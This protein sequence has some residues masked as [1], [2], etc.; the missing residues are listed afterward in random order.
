MA[1]DITN[2]FAGH[3]NGV[4]IEYGQSSFSGTGLTVQVPCSFGKITGC[5]ITPKQ[6]TNSA[7]RYVCDL[8]SDGGVTTV[9]RVC[10]LRQVSFP[11]DNAQS[12]SSN[13]PF[14]PLMIAQRGMVLSNVNWF[15]GTSWGPSS[16]LFYLGTSASNGAYINGSA[17]SGA[18]TN[19]TATTF[20]SF[21]ASSIDDGTVIGFKTT[22]GLG[23]SS[24]P[25]ATSTGTPSAT[26]TGSA[27]PSST[28]SITAS[29]T[30]SATAS[31]SV[32]AEQ[33]SDCFVA[34]NYFTPES[35]LQFSYIILGIW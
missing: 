11:I 35:D 16:P 9:T 22:D 20:S 34:V 32:Q 26:S 5:F 14:T 18:A 28:Q 3:M 6:E 7:E 30:D 4:Q 21:V 17:I 12:E 2:H 8:V 10:A 29:A 27:S 13:L 24:T 19:N 25:S 1:V 33:P 15:H 23:Q 31:A